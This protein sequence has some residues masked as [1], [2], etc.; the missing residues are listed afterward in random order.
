[1][2]GGGIHQS[3]VLLVLDN[4]TET[5]NL[6]SASG[7][8]YQSPVPYPYDPIIDSNLVCLFVYSE[9]AY[10]LI[11]NRYKHT[12]SRSRSQAVTSPLVMTAVSCTASILLVLH[13]DTLIFL[14]WAR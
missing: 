13:N 10:W 6:S 7:S 2:G 12:V 1:M 3:S 5:L 11:G 14:L 8:L 4:P 9:V